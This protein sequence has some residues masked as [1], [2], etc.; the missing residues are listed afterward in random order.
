MLL[1]AAEFTKAQI[2]DPG[3][4]I[5]NAGDTLKGI[6]ESRENVLNPDFVNFK[7]SP[8]DPAPKRYDISEIRQFTYGNGESFERHWVSMTMDPIELSKAT[9]R[10]IEVRFDTVFLK[11]IQKGSA[12]AFYSYEDQIKKRYYILQPGNSRPL[13]LG[14]RVERDGPNFTYRFHFRETL[15]L[16]A[17]STGK[18]TPVLRKIIK[19]TDYYEASLL[20]VIAEL[21]GLNP[22]RSYV[23]KKEGQGFR[24]GGGIRIGGMKFQDENELSKNST[25]SVSP[26]IW[27]MAGYD[28]PK[29]PR[30]GKVVFRAEMFFSTIAAESHTFD[31]RFISASITVDHRF[32]QLNSG[33]G[34]NTMINFVNKPEVKVFGGLGI[35]ANYATYSYKFTVTRTGDNSVSV[36]EDDSG[37]PRNLWSSIP[38]RAGVVIKRRFEATLVY[39]P[40]RKMNSSSSYYMFKLDFLEAGFIYHLGR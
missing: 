1:Y 17:E 24:V 11:N 5:T 32:T 12:V 26:G 19:K 23:E 9:D 36:M 15:Q 33:L 7:S 27:L 31:D 6:L 28:L 2:Y 21:N 22:V 8:G 37:E 10:R 3:Y 40:S 38:V 16:L 14:Y 29:N 30:V 34:L 25:A 13:E 4:V 20:R 18:D 39:S 35:R